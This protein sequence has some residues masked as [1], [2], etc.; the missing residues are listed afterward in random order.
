M[1]YEHPASDSLREC[2]MSLTSTVSGSSTKK[3]SNSPSKRKELYFP[4]T[5]EFQPKSAVL[6][7]HFATNLHFTYE[8][9]SAL[10]PQSACAA[11]HWPVFKFHLLSVIPSTSNK[12]LFFKGTKEYSIGL[13]PSGCTLSLTCTWTGSIPWK[14]GQSNKV[15]EELKWMNVEMM[16]SQLVKQSPWWSADN[17]STCVFLVC[18]GSLKTKLNKLPIKLIP[19]RVTVWPLNNII[20]SFFES[21]LMP[22]RNKNKPINYYIEKKIKQQARETWWDMLD[23]EGIIKLRFG[24]IN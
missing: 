15:W 23:S 22:E 24:T 6:I 10:H 16:F 1:P 18:K 3:H 11:L 14:G 2:A 17:C 5:F 8:L 21:L 7:L 4:I 9:Q 20:H 19:T 12:S 13:T